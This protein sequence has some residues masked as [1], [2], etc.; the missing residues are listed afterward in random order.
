LY[1]KASSIEFIYED[2]AMAFELHQGFKRL[3]TL[4]FTK[5]DGT[6]GEVEGAPAWDF[7]PSG[8]A[9][10]AVA[11]DGMSAELTWVGTGEGVL[12]VTADGDLSAL[13]APLRPGFCGFFLDF[14][15]S[16]DGHSWG[17]RY[18]HL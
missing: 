9:E 4:T 6:T 2:I 8:I 12:T 13:A 15:G 17:K 1:N 18:A 16:H 5:S 7:Q 3:I 10:L 11:S 14:A